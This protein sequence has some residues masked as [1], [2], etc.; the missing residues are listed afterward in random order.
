MITIKRIKKDYIV[1]NQKL[2]EIRG[3]KA[4]HTHCPDSLYNNAHKTALR[5]RYNVLN[6]RLPRHSKFIYKYVGERNF[7]RYIESHIRVSTGEYR[8]KLLQFIKQ[9]EDKQHYVNIQK[10]VR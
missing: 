6:D 1:I 9:E 7:K 5:I 2:K 3:F 4:S 10:G 8:Q